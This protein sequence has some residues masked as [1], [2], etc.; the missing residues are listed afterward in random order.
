MI[1][2]LKDIAQGKADFGDHRSSEWPKVRK[3]HLEKQPTC[4]ACGGNKTLEVHHI[5]PF[6]QHPELELDPNNLI[7]LCENKTNGV[8]CH[9]LFGHLGNFKSINTNIIEDS[10]IWYQKITKRP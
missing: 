8:N 9:L 6:N 4:V 1:S 3:E 7:T 10:N 5:K 2:H